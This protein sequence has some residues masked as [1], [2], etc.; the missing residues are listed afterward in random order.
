MF[1]LPGVFQ[2][3][4]ISTR[5]V[6]CRPSLVFFGHGAVLVGLDHGLQRQQLLFRPHGDLGDQ[7]FLR[8]APVKI[9]MI[10]LGFLSSGSEKLSDWLMSFCWIFESWG[11]LE[12]FVL[13][14]AIWRT[15]EAL[16]KWDTFISTTNTGVIEHLLQP[17]HP[18]CSALKGKL[19]TIP[20]FGTS[21]LGR[22]DPFGSSY[23]FNISHHL[24]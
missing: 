13:L 22:S 9:L 10:F 19:S 5:P 18:T 12:F 20:A 2:A 23:R 21:S 14:K 11:E 6:F 15:W 17:I 7:A 4:S 24:R 8:K 1:L 16:E 3:G